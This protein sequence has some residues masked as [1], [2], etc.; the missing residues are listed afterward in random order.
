MSL[1]TAVCSAVFNNGLIEE[2]N[3]SQTFVFLKA[4][5]ELL[6][7]FQES[8]LKNYYISIFWACFKLAP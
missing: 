8:F 1:F 2:K 7:S 3:C 5:R 4:S 6:A